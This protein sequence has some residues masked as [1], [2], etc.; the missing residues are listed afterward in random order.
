MMLSIGDSASNLCQLHALPPPSAIKNDIIMHSQQKV[1]GMCSLSTPP[2]EIFLPR[3]CL[4]PYC[5]SKLITCKVT[6]SLVSQLDLLSLVY[7]QASQH[8][9]HFLTDG[10]QCPF[11]HL[12]VR[13]SNVLPFNNS[14]Q[15]FSPAIQSSDQISLHLSNTVVQKD[16]GIGLCIFTF[17]F[18]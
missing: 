6:V 18:I 12:I 11:T 3:L 15:Q 10:T 5:M 13:Q 9:T 2:R 1:Q 8:N 16:G 4:M 14:V 17:A 7:F